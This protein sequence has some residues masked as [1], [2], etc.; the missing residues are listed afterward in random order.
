[1]KKQRTNKKKRAGFTLIELVVVMAII[2]IL[3]AIAVPRLSGY[4]KEA[5]HTKA[6]ATSQTVYTAAATYDATNDITDDGSGTYAFKESDI[7][8][9]LDSSVIIVNSVDEVDSEGDAFVSVTRGGTT[10]DEYTVVVYD[11]SQANN[12][13]DTTY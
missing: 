4:T 8:Q 9:F 3:A 13:L 6:V 2:G 5:Q 7:G 11:P 10:A 12:K 1:M